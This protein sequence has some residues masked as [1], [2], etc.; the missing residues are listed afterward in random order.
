MVT[1]WL[2]KLSSIRYEEKHNE[3]TKISRRT[4]GTGKWLLDS[5]EFLDWRDA[6]SRILWCYGIR[7]IAFYPDVLPYPLLIDIY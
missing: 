3:N 5:P 7:K 1:D 6:D 2:H 4:L